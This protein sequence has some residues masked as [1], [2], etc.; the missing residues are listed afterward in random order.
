M[1]EYKNIK[2]PVSLADIVDKL[3]EGEEFSSRAEYVKMLIRID[4][5]KRGLMK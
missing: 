4:L 2:I 3:V 5:Q 1:T